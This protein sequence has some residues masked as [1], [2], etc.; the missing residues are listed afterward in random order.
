MKGVLGLL[1]ATLGLLVAVTTAAAEPSDGTIDG[2]IS[3]GT[4][5]AGVPI[6]DAV[7]LLVFGKAAQTLQ[8]QF[9]AVLD[10]DGRYS[11]ANL[12][13]SANLVYLVR[14]RHAGVAY[15]SSE[16]I[17]LQ[18]DPAG[19]ADVQVFETT[20]SDAAIR[21]ER[22]NLL[23]AS[24]DPGLVQ[25]Y[26]MGTLVNSGDVTFVPENPQA[27][28]LAH[29]L[30]FGLPSG[31]LGAQLETGFSNADLG[32]A[33][34]GVQLTGPV[35][36]GRHEFALTFRM[37]YTGTSADLGLQLPYPTATY[38]VYLPDGELRLES[39]RL[40]AQGRTDFGTRTFI[41]A[42][43]ENVSGTAVVAAQLKG[44]PSAG[45]ELNP[46][47]IGLAVVGAVLVVV[48]LGTVIYGAWAARRGQ[49]ALAPLERE[50]QRL[51]TRL[52]VL[53]ERFEAGRIPP[54][55]YHSARA[56]GKRRLVQLTRTPP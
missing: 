27:G 33:P 9:T 13:R 36:P 51:I 56:R 24:A 52:V 4:A 23:V 34:G 31:A 35:V 30:R 19:H 26:E 47:Q 55:R 20:T 25:L 37:P 53:D 45:G 38:N 43:A 44:L 5:G 17:D 10:D 48:G 1:V 16:L 15:S 6:G 18:Q 14:V 32:P 11:F 2:Q 21:L 41:L 46:I 28:A 39:D 50:R 7:T 29:G 40:A 49:P 8:D 42:T 54:H 3:N 12:E 22:L